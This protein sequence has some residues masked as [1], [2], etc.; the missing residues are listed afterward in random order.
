ME[1]RNSNVLGDDKGLDEHDPAC[2]DDGQEG[3]DVHY[4]DSIKYDKTWASQGSVEE[5]HVV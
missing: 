3:D 2:S 5:Q 4:A 1:T